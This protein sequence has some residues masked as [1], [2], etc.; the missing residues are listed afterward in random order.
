MSVVTQVFRESLRARAQLG[1][2]PVP[3]EEI[4]KS[5]ESCTVPVYVLS[6]NKR[7]EKSVKSVKSV[8]GA[9]GAKGAGCEWV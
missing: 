6:V 5:Q 9:K 3:G 4:R 1:T 2:I 7:R 8:K